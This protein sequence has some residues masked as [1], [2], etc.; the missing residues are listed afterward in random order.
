LKSE[1]ATKSEL[2][3][4]YAL[5]KRELQEKSEE[6]IKV[7]LFVYYSGHGVVDVTSQIVLN[8]LQP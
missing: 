6:G 5:I 8:E 1:N 7:F 3:Q 4:T 2:E